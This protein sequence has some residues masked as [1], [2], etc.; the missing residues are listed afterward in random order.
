M[1]PLHP[2]SIVAYTYPPD[3]LFLYQLHRILLYTTWI[4]FSFVYPPVFIHLHFLQAQQLTFRHVFELFPDV[5]LW[6][7]KLVYRKRHRYRKKEAH[8]KE[9]EPTVTKPGTLLTRF[10]QDK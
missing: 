1:S 10:F 2:A 9:K 7:S 5:G 3:H 8:G 4:S 6:A